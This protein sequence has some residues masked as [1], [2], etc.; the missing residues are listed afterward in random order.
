MRPAGAAYLLILAVVSG[1]GEAA[2]PPPTA[3]VLTARHGH[4]MVY[5]EARR[6]LLLFGG[7]GAEG[8]EPVGDRSSLWVWDG[9]RWTRLGTSGPSARYLVSLA[10][11]AARQRVVLYGG[12]TGVFPSITVLRDT[13]EWD[14]TSWDRRADV[15]PSPRVHQAMAYDRARSRVVLYGGFDAGAAR[16]LHDIWEWNGSS[17]TQQGPSADPGTVAAGI[18]YDERP[19]TLY[20]YSRIASGDVVTDVWDGGTLV[21]SAAAGPGCIPHQSSMV[22]LGSAPGGVLFYSGTCGASGS[23]PETWRWDGSTWARVPGTQPPFRLNAAMA[24]D[25]DRNRSV[26]FG[27]EVGAGVP[28]LG[29]TW[30]FDGTAWAM[31]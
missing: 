3:I 6:Q 16:E 21:R 23:S 12:Q 14:G 27:G 30:E 29:D 22:A 4:A 31:R 15:G 2:A 17:W 19:G 9:A 5:D 24:Y 20:L 28:D 10:Y 18:A 8:T 25:R 13:W 1:C 7:T 26:L 11:D